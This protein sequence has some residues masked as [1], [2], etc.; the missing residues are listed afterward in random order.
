MICKHCGLEY[1]DDLDACPGCGASNDDVEAQV[2]S[3]EE[4]DS[5]SG[6]TIETGPEES[7]RDDYRVYD[8]EDLRRK[9]QQQ[10]RKARWRRI[11]GLVK[12]NGRAVLVLALIIFCVIFLLPTLLGFALIGLGVFLVLTIFRKYFAGW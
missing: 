8:Q 9:E 11:W 5:F 4:R 12:L 2:L 6:V 10:A 1:P 3:E 7:S